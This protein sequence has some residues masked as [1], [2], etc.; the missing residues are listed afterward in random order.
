MKSLYVT[1][2]LFSSSFIACMILR[3]EMY[4]ILIIAVSFSS[5][6]LDRQRTKSVCLYMTPRVTA[7][8][9]TVLSDNQDVPF[10]KKKQIFDCGVTTI[11]SFD[12]LL[13][14]NQKRLTAIA[15]LSFCC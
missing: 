7:F 8:L 12:I 6:C 10:K 14:K 2:T 3:N 1:L 13:I 4:I 11:R 15:I 5:V 9:K